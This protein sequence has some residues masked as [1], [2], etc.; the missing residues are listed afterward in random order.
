MIIRKKCELCGHS[1]ENSKFIMPVTKDKVICGNCAIKLGKV[2]FV[3]KPA[4]VA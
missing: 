4:M 1:T 2:F 3:T